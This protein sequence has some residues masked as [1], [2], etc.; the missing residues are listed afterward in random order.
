MFVP[1]LLPAE[2]LG[3]TAPAPPEIEVLLLGPAPLVVAL[4][5]VPGV[6]PPQGLFEFVVV[7]VVP[8]GLWMLP[9][10]APGAVEGGVAGPVVRGPAAVPVVPLVPVPPT[11]AP[12]VVPC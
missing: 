8:V 6:E 2:A 5:V 9:V 4:E 1:V 10:P 12:P 11:L 3:A 7:F